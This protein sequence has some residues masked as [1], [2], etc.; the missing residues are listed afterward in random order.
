MQVRLSNKAEKFLL[1]LDDNTYE[2]IKSILLFLETNPVPFKEF[3]VKKISGTKNGFRIR[4]GKIRIIYS[5]EK[6]LGLIFIELIDY[7]SETIYK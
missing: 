6:Q 4:K 3:D 2:K 1:K 7:R 5:I